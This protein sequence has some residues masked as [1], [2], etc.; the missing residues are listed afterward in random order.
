MILNKCKNFVIVY[1]FMYFLI[2]EKRS[3]Y[4][5]NFCGI[6]FYEVGYLKIVIIR[7]KDKR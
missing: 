1:F 2:A 7:E 5:N 3:G 4:F 6:S